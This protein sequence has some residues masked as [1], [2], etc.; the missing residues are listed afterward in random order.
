MVFNI[1]IKKYG[2]RPKNGGMVISVLLFNLVNLKHRLFYTIIF[3]RQNFTEALLIRTTVIMFETCNGLLTQ[4][5]TYRSSCRIYSR[6]L[7]SERGK[8][9]PRGLEF[10]LQYF[11]CFNQRFAYLIC[12]STWVG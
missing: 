1:K 7:K 3:F 5:P 12:V 9:T 8:R 11:S 2:T 4:L 6:S 10:C